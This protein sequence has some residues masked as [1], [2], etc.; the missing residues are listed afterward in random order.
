MPNHGD[1]KVWWIPQIPMTG[2]EAPVSSLVEARLL[3]DALADYDLFQLRHNVRGDYANAG[4][5]MV[6]DANDDE[7]GSKDE[8]KGSWVEWYDDDGKDIDDYTL[9]EL[10]DLAG[11]LAPRG[12]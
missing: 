5:L 1:L 3:L 10:R 12:H 9:S 4:G 8:P 2:F 6:F 11:E 7:D